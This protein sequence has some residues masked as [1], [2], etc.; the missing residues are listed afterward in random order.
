VKFLLLA[1]ALMGFIGFADGQTLDKLTIFIGLDEGREVINGIVKD[2][3]GNTIEGVTVQITTILETSVVTTNK[4]GEF[5]YK[6]PETPSDGRFSISVKAQKDGYSTG[7]ANTS[8]YINNINNIE[9]R[10]PQEYGFKVVTSDKL[11]NDPVAIKILEQIEQNK[12]KEEE[13]QQKLREIEEQQNFIVK[14]REISNQV[15]LN[16][17]QSWL[18]QFDP[19]K[20]RNAFSTFVSQIDMAVQNIYWGQFNF[21][22]SKTNEGLAAM[23]QVLKNNGTQEEARQAFYEKAAIKQ[24]DM[25]RVN[26]ELNIKYAKN[27]TA[28]TNHTEQVKR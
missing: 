16:D 26:N 18:D 2:Q 20:P 7:Y 24:S 9:K 19:F 13:R 27:N 17:L 28:Y 11:K 22:E 25:D 12:K 3:N 5:S 15:L 1:F 8:F 21:T 6:L 4:D 23:Q 14:Q 10:A